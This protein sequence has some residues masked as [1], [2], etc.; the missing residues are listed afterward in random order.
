M[1]LKKLKTEENLPRNRRSP[2]LSDFFTPSKE[3]HKYKS[4]SAIIIGGIIGFG[5]YEIYNFVK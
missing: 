5:G 2:V 3:M 4:L 1:N